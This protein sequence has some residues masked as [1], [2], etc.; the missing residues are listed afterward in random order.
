MKKIY[1]ILVLF[2]TI[3]IVSCEDV[4]DIPLETS[5][6]K[7]VIDANI[8]WEK[9]TTG[10]NQEIKLSLTTG[11]YES[12][13]PPASGA[14]VSL[15]NSNNVNFIFTEVAQ[16]GVYKC[17]NFQPV[18]NE[19][20]TLKVNYKGENYTA[21]DKLYATPVVVNTVQELISGI[22]EDIYRVTFYYQDNPNEV[23]YYL[24]QTK[25]DIDLL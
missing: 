7:L 23:N 12:T 20:Y 4:V 14:I 19:V 16:T 3:S 13:Q 10:N 11:F 8:N 18:I 21:T 17:T 22:S 5:A 9:S 15:T 2:I 24:N 25:A 6:P 1:K